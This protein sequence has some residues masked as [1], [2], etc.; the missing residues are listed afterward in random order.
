VPPEAV[1][2]VSNAAS[3][4]STKTGPFSFIAD[5]L[6]TVLKAIDG[7]FE[8][9]HVPYSY[10][11]SIILLTV[12]VKILTF[13]LSKSSVESSLAMQALQP[14]IKEIQE[15]NKNNPEKVQQ[16]TAQLYQKSGVNPLAGT[17]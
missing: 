7:G 4:A 17:D 5:G 2:A 16:L 14:Q 1:D 3:Q 9:L 12:V 13:P 15:K 8:L 10:G 11:F 6:E